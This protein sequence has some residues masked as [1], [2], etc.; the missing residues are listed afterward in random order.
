MVTKL[1]IGVDAAEREETIGGDGVRLGQHALDVGVDGTLADD[2]E[3]PHLPPL[4]PANMQ[5]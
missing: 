4:L 5:D 1:D 3:E 2:G